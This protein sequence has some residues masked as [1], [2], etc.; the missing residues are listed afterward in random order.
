MKE[1]IKEIIDCLS[2][3][4]NEQF[5]STEDCED[6]EYEQRLYEILGEVKS[7]TYVLAERN[8]NASYENQRENQCGV[9]D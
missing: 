4:D 9:N 7:M 3:F 5:L 2:R 8:F 6:D 1:V